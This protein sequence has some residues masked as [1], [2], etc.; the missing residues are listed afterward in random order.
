LFPGR[1]SPVPVIR[2]TGRPAAENLDRHPRAAYNR[3]KLSNL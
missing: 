3:L 2:V 1:D